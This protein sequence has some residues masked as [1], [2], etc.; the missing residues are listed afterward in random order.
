LNPATRFQKECQAEIIDQGQDAQ[1]RTLS[2]NWLLAATGHKYSYHFSWLGRPIIQLPQDILAMQEIIWKVQPNLIVE[3]GIAHG[4]SLVFSAAMLELNAACGGPAEAEVLGVD[5]DI[6]SHNR[7]AIEEHPMARR[8]SM[9]EGS[10][11][12]P[13]VADQ[14]RDRAEIADRVLVCLDSNHT[15]EHVLAEL[16]VYAPLVTIDSYCVVFDTV[17]EQLPASTYP[18]RTWGIG[19]NPMTA[20]SDYLDRHPEF[21]IDHAIDAKLALS[22]LPNGY[23][24]RVSN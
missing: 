20:V 9:I 15:H 3:T 16:E 1:F 22:S 8:I 11:V 5:I 7:R 23:L 10:S 24:R 4:G 21:Q 18:G 6:R 14:V 17:I 2:D 12:D 13:L 19:N